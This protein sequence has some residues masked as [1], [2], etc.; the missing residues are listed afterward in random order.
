MGF[1]VKKCKQHEN[2]H[3]TCA[4]CLPKYILGV[5]KINLSTA[6]RQRKNEKSL[7]Q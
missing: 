4:A 5:P 2:N 6:H 1:G 3:N 7:M